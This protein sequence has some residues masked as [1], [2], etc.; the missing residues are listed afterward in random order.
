LRARL[1]RVRQLLQMQQAASTVINDHGEHERAPLPQRPRSAAQNSP[2]FRLEP[3]PT[4]N[5]TKRVEYP[6]ME[7]GSPR[8]HSGDIAKMKGQPIGFRLVRDA[9]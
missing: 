2:T 1:N 8:I 5:F 9:E 7:S 6:L 3:R 4:L